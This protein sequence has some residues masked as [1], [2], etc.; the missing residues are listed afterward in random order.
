V[1]HDDTSRR[2]RRVLLAGGLG[3]LAAVA[4]Q[5]IGRPLPAAAG[6]GAVMLGD[7]N[8]T[9]ALDTS[10]ERADVRSSAVFANVSKQQ[11][12]IRLNRAAPRSLAVGWFVVN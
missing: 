5:A 11:F 12:T 3:A 4:A 2:S 8:R 10:I 6:G 9:T 1:I 7:S